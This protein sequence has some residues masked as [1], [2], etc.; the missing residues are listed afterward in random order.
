MVGGKCTVPEILIVIA[1]IIGSMLYCWMYTSFPDD[2]DNQSE[3]D[4]SDEDN[5]LVKFLN[6]HS[7]D[8]DKS[9]N[10]VEDKNNE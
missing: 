3:E 10:N 9:K 8:K 2:E 5:V 1:I 7:N 6:E 4:K